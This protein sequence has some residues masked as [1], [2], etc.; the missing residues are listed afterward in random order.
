MN[1]LHSSFAVLLSLVLLSA[2]S[3]SRVP[4]SSPLKQPPV[5]ERIP[6]AVTIVYADE[7]RNHQCSAG[8]GYLAASWDIALGPPSIDMFNQIFA[9]FFGKGVVQAP[10]LASEAAA[11]PENVFEVRL[12]EFDGCEAKWPIVGATV[13][14][15]YQVSLRDRGGAVLAS[16][17][18]R[19]RA[20]AKDNLQAYKEPVSVMEPETWYLGAATSMAMRRAAADLV[21]NL[22][23]DLRFRKWQGKK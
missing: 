17:E 14:V 16:W 5:V 6:G 13:E 3:T 7:L 21:V 12:L 19:G 11:E 18:A 15:A 22:D 4:L 20:G 10:N 1:C 23:R 8:K 2:C 9:A